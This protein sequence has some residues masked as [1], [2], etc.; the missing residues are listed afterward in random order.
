MRFMR[1]LQG[2]FKSNEGEPKRQALKMVPGQPQVHG[3]SF[4]L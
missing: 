3:V 1:N 2:L 4:K